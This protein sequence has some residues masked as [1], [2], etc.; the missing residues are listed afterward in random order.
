MTD[1]TVQRQLELSEKIINEMENQTELLREISTNS[2]KQTQLLE[3]LLRDV[4]KKQIYWN[5]NDELRSEYN[6]D[7]D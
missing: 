6:N 2:N 1:L 7:S 5:Y 3:K 4:H